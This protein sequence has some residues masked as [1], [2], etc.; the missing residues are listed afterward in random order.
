MT[1]TVRS[2]SPFLSTFAGRYY[3]DPAIFEQE[4]ECL[5][6]AMWYYAC[7]VDAVPHTG[8]YCVVTVGRESIIV[9]RD[10]EGVLHARRTPHSQ[11][12]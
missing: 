9:V 7:R 6:S 10:K 2:N 11:V 1:T 3:Y 5:F 4:Q 8:S 12:R